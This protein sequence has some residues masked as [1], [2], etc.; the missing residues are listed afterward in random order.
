MTAPRLDRAVEIDRDRLAALEARELR[1]F[2]DA[3]PRSRALHEAARA[4]LVSGVPMP[5]MVKW[6]GRFPIVVE[7][8]EGAHLRCVDGHEYVD[9]SLGDTGAMSGHGAP[10]TLDAIRAQLARG[11]THM[12]PTEDAAIVGAELARRFGLPAWQ[13]TLSATDANRFALRLARALT[14]R[15]KILVFDWCYHGTVDE[16]FAVLADG[17]AG[18]GPRV[19][20]R[21][22]SVGPQVDVAET[23][24]VVEFNDLGAL[25]AALA[26]EDVAVVLAEPAMTNIG[27]VLPDPGFHD[28]LREITRRT[29]TLLLLDETHTLCAG[30][31]GCTGA[32]GL[33]PDIV[34]V[35]KT[36]GGGVP[37]GAY[38][39]SREL[40]D[41][42]DR[43][44][45]VQDSDVGGIGGT[46]AGNALSLAAARATLGSVL[47]G[48]AFA[49]MIEL[50]EGWTAGVESVLDARRV[51][52]HVT[53]LG[54]RAE[55]HFRPTAPR[56]GAEAA[57][58][59][60][61]PL[62]RYLHLA[63]LNRGVLMTPFHNMALMSPATTAADVDRHTAM[64]DEVV[65][66][67]VAA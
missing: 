62:E 18:A 65:T 37:I 52:W 49:R 45:D 9:F 67:L 27:I 38:G 4:S 25:E 30:P 33:Q 19:V 44:I 64:F 6:A 8:A 34:V 41:E 26:P 36:I 46:L 1:R 63:A 22:G 14:R 29:G 17:P 47:T 54:C 50:A 28:A 7:S 61:V 2:A 20:P 3:H 10:A 42:I 11:L 40:A 39:L 57:A 59:T 13:F 56:T 12:L 48:E 58:A 24:K 43:L 5:W 35:G 32:F 53:R 15:P 23:T 31:G 60:D 55:Y 16:T 51:P 66:E 21:P